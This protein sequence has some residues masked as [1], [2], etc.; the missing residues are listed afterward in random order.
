VTLVGRVLGW[1]DDDLGPGAPVTPRLI[2]GDD[3]TMYAT[4]EVNRSPDLARGST[5]EVNSSPP[6]DRRAAGFGHVT[7]DVDTAVSVVVRSVHSREG[8]DI[9]G[10]AQYEALVT[11]VRRAVEVNRR[12]PDYRY[13]QVE[14]EDDRSGTNGNFF[15]RDLTV[16]FRRYRD[17][18]DA[19]A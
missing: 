10:D 13:V 5:V 16:A 8:G 12:T 19:T 17:L 7:E 9:D 15:R 2:N 3:S 1:I 11:A 6:T 14:R 18:P 4:G